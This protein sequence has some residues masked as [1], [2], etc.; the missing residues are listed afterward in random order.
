MREWVMLR[1]SAAVLIFGGGA[2]CLAT[3]ASGCSAYL[4]AAPVRARKVVCHKGKKTLELPERAVEAHLKHGD[5]L[6]PC[7]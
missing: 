2:I 4:E 5:T 3:L 1:K 6:G 7:S